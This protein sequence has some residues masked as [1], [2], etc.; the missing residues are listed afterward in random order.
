MCVCPLAQR[1]W[2]LLVV[3]F[4]EADQLSAN[5]CTEPIL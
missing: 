1:E 5:I 4:R 2:P 3:R